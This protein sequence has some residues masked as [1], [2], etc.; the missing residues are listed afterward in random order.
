L[1]NIDPVGMGVE[2]L[3]DPRLIGIRLI[4]ELHES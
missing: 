3:V 4:A 1:T 2:D